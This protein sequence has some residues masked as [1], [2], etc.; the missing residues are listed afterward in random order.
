MKQM[1]EILHQLKTVV[2]PTIGFQPSKVVQDFGS[3]QSSTVS[4]YLE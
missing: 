2:Y 1:E 3:S 4:T